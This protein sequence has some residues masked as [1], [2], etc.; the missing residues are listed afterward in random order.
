[1]DIMHE[2]KKKKKKGNS[3]S[4]KHKSITKKIKIFK[5]FQNL[6]LK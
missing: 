2:I 1:M 4:N 5:I 6:R 3:G